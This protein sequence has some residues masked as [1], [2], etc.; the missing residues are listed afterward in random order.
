M[1]VLLG[2]I[3][4]LVVTFVV[5]VVVVPRVQA[6]TRFRQRWEDDVVELR[7]L[8]EDELPE[9]LKELRAVGRVMYKMFELLT[10]D[11]TPDQREQL[12]RA[13]EAS[14]EQYHHGYQ[15]C[16]NALTRLS[17]LEGRL[18]LVHRRAELWRRLRM[19]RMKLQLAVYGGNL[20]MP[21]DSTSMRDGWDKAWSRIDKAYDTLT[22]TTKIVIQNTRPPRTYPV[23]RLCRWLRRKLTRHEPAR[24]RLVPA[25][26]VSNGQHDEPSPSVDDSP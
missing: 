15:K 9:A 21:P 20:F 18:S 19:H 10:E 12:Q 14:R 1:E 7:T 24:A 3:V 8:V 26:S 5:Q 6:H 13:C 25:P 23:R 4:T 16:N 2:G 17:R 22:N 11:P